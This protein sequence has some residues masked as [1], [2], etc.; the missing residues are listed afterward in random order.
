M[1]LDPRGPLGCLFFFC[2]LVLSIII[3]FAVLG[4]AIWRCP[5]AMAWQAKPSGGYSIGSPP[6]ENNVSEICAQLLKADSPWTPESVTGMLANVQGEGGMNPWRWQNDS[7]DPTHRMGYGLFG[8]TPA[9]KYIG[10]SI[11]VKLPGYGPNLSTTTITTGASARD[12][13]AQVEFM[14]EGNVGWVSSCWRTYWDPDDYPELY[15]LRQSCL[16]RYGN[17]STISFNQFKECTDYADATFIFLACFEGPAVPNYSARLNYAEQ[18]APFVGASN[19][20]PAW[21]LFAFRKGGI[22][23]GIYN[24][25]LG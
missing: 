13:A 21:L 14:N 19:R 5:H 18:I 10:N 4:I 7:Y 15:Q 9:S 8:F 17:G 22:Y 20:F 1:R 12:G 3:F 23:H 24:Q 2:G 11:A 16:D 6:W 25:P